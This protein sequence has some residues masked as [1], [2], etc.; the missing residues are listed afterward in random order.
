MAFSTICWPNADWTGALPSAGAVEN[1]RRAVKREE[2]ELPAVRGRVALSAPWVRAAL[3]LGAFVAALAVALAGVGSARTLLLSAADRRFYEAHGT[4]KAMFDPSSVFNRYPVLFWVLALLAIGVLGLPY[5]WLAA[6]S[7]PDRGFCFARPV[8]L[9]L[10]GWVTWWLASAGAMDFSRGSIA[11]AIALVAAGGAVIVAPR[12]AEFLGWIGRRRRVLAVEEALFWSLF[13]AGVLVRWANPDLWHPTLG[14][15]K[16]MDL[17]YLN[18]VVK[19]A[20]FPP[21]D[22]WFAG[23]QMNYYYFG[24][25]LVAVLVKLTSVVP[26]VAYN[27]AVPTLFAFLGTAVFGVAFALAGRPRARARALGLPAA[28]FLGT[29]FVAVIGNLGELRVLFDAAGRSVPIEWWYWNPTRVIPHPTTEAGPITE[30]PVFTYLFGDLHAHAMALPFTAVALGLAI[31]FLREDSR[32]RDTP[33]RAV[34]LALLALV[35]GA[36]W[37]LNTWDAPTYA[38]IAVLA[39]LAGWWAR[40]PRSLSGLVQTALWCGLLLVLAYVFF[41]PFH[42]HYEGVFSGVD[43]W[44]GSRTP[45]N[46]YLTI[47]GLFLFVI[48]TAVAVDLAT[49]HD[50]GAVAR[51]VRLAFKSWDR[52]ARFR[53]LHRL[54]VRGSRA[55]RVGIHGAAAAVVAVVVLAALGYGVSALA[56][57]LAALTVLALPRRR[58]RLVEQHSQRLWAAALALFLIGLAITVGVEYAVAK[59]ID[60]GRQNTVFKF[61]LQ[62]WLL[63]GVTAAICVQ[64]MYQ[65]LPGLPRLWRAAWRAAFVALVVTASLYP[66][67]AT[68]ARI[69]DRFD[70]SVGPTLDGL[71][72]T[73]KAIFG[74]RGVQ[75]RLAYDA[76]AIRWL[77]ETVT[78]SPVVAEVNTY[79]TLYGWGNRYAMFTGNPAIVGW[80][81]H[82]RQQRPPQSP[83]VRQR[84][85]DVQ[86]AYSTTQPELASRIF[87]RYGVSYF[88]VG[89]LERAYFPQGQ[90]KWPAGEGTLWHTVY[91]NP[92]V[93]IYQ[94]D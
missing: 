54:F 24:F 5:V 35:V 8:G 61:Y 73:R 63:W 87:R 11:V 48:A 72:F 4:W 19:S 23:G 64:R 32:G 12:R 83:L 7:L 56:A 62:V 14:G 50:L 22:P 6:K 29:L 90:D 81:Y 37:L 88:V 84:I 39:I 17:A 21:Y 30:F 55:Y 71:A 10:V 28:A 42:R 86:T 26:Y 94:L 41:L 18:A 57:G 47:H 3:L 92:G 89:P 68:R 2:L 9:L 82:Q 27:L 59:N 38:L 78:G 43:W 20:H 31:A 13:T 70:T 25:V 34:R 75:M 40:G 1:A 52:I 93:R 79:P 49:A 74:D 65:W 77:Q 46:D 16:P 76:D 67:L 36:L 15:E 60:V 44:R 66:I 91:R 58:R 33:A 85:A 45:L 51:G 53:E 69:G 80:D